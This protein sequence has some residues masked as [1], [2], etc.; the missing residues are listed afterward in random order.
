MSTNAVPGQQRIAIPA[1][2]SDSRTIASTR[3]QRES[4]QQ[5][6]YSQ[7]FSHGHVRGPAA[8]PSKSRIDTRP[9]P[10]PPSRGHKRS[11]T[12]EIKT[13]VYETQ[14][15][16][17]PSNGIDGHSRTTS[18][19]STG[20]KIAELS[21]QLRARLSYAAAKV[22][23]SRQL[24]Q[25]GDSTPSKGSISGVQNTIQPVPESR[26][27]HNGSLGMSHSQISDSTING[28]IGQPGANTARQSSSL[29]Q[30]PKLAPPVDIVTGDRLK[31]ARRR[32]SPNEA[33]GL[34]SHTSTPRHRRYH[35]EHEGKTGLESKLTGPVDATPLRLKKNAQAL[36]PLLP[37]N[38]SPVKQRTP[39]QNALMEKDAIETLLFM[40][41]PD[42]SGYH[43]STRARKSSMSV[44]IEAQ[45]AA[46]TQN[47]SQA[48]NTSAAR[49]MPTFNF[50]DNNAIRTA[51][52]V[53]IIGHHSVGLEAQAGDEID[54]LLD[55][56]E[57]DKGSE[58]ESHVIP[59][60]FDLGV[61]DQSGSYNFGGA[62]R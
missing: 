56:M 50:F 8:S 12:G 1:T 13:A 43:S 3:S 34:V 32:P 37:S 45:M 35:S 41:S 36:T 52:P 2:D 10:P 39:S 4:W 60:D 31:T 48:S 21:A 26:Q 23:Q 14:S 6:A 7:P 17:R 59:Y 47:S 42:N 54:R 40:S 11:A 5:A 24:R 18:L 20:N 58:A 38:G 16:A 49:Q 30:T 27:L 15:R 19:D 28:S 55:Q 46:S 33:D 9:P 25:H 53:P 44:S 61:D 62:D 57:V 29:S 51:V 22:E